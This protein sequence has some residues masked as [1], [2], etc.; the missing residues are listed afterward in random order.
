MD[1]PDQNPEPAAANPANGPEPS[2]P[3]AAADEDAADPDSGDGAPREPA[4][5]AGSGG[6]RA[7]GADRYRPL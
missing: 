5:D 1:R 4:A 3:D 6:R 7:H 2:V